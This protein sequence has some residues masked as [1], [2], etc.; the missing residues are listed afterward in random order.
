MNNLFFLEFVQD[1]PCFLKHR[2]PDDIVIALRP[3]VT[4]ELDM[5]GIPY[6]CLSTDYYTHEEYMANSYECRQGLRPTLQVLDGEFS[7]FL[8]GQYKVADLKPFQTFIYLFNFC[9]NSLKSKIFELSMLFCKEGDIDR[10][11]FIKHKSWPITS[12]I[13]FFDYESVY[14]KLIYLMQGKYKY[15]IE[16]IDNKYSVEND[17]A[18]LYSSHLFG[19]YAPKTAYFVKRIEGIIKRFYKVKNYSPSISN[20][21]GNI[22]SINCYELSCI[23]QGLVSLGWSIQEFP[24]DMLDGN[25]ISSRWDKELIG[26]F[27]AS[28]DLEKMFQ[29]LEVNFFSTM[30]GRLE[31]FCRRIESI[32]HNYQILSN[33]INNNKLD[34]V[35]FGTHAPFNMENVLLPLI[36]RD[37]KIPYVCWMHGGHGANYK[38]PGYEISDYTFG[39]HYF[40]YGDEIKNIIDSYYPQYNLIT[41]VAGS[42]AILKRYQNYVIPKNKKKVITFITRAFGSN[43]LHVGI[44]SP[45][46]RF[47][48][49][50][51]SKA[52][53]ELLVHHRYKYR[54]IIRTLDRPQRET[55][56]RFLKYH[57]AEEI[58][59]IAAYEMPFEKIA[60]ITDLFIGLWVS[61][62]FWEACFTHAD[63]FLIDNSDLTDNA[64][65]IISK[66]AFWYDDIT[67]FIEGLG[68]YLEQ[69]IFY[70]RNEDKSFLRSYMDID[71]KDYIPGYVSGL[72]EDIIKTSKNKGANV[73]DE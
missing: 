49:W 19:F 62:A 21:K 53:L 36:C 30:K 16:A 34:I 1:I 52:I 27:L 7:K 28:K 47:S 4:L 68:H 63:I 29:F 50:V 61:T 44:D 3:E 43:I 2:D 41:H 20:K 26:R 67:K 5:Q 70:Q 17:I 14:E 55:F 73:I 71:R 66:R 38:I 8:D 51:P 64:K 31:Y 6:K 39:Q 13:Y 42:P 11:K 24:V 46:Y 40:V 15:T 23:K 37:K 60:G 33:Y 59:L 58:E 35:F 45:Y 72:I 18:K 54:I 32:F 12:Y 56:K 22:L 57:N 69:G 25:F 9:L 10:V 48:H 65:G